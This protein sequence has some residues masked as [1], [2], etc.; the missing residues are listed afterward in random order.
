MPNVWLGCLL[1]RGSIDVEKALAPGLLVL[2][3]GSALVGSARLSGARGLSVPGLREVAVKRKP[4]AVFPF[5]PDCEVE[6]LGERIPARLLRRD[7][8][9][10][11]WIQTAEGVF[12][13]AAGSLY[14]L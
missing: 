6:C 1:P 2:V 10:T 4:N 14:K 11:V 8:L 12:T 7:T 5:E 9:Q 3:E 13:C